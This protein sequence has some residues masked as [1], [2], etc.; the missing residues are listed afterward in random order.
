MALNEY[1]PPPGKVAISTVVEINGKRL[2]AQ[3]FA[4]AEPWSQDEQYQESMKADLLR[5][6]GEAIVKELRPEITATLSPPTL[7]E[8]LNEALRPFDY[9]Y[10]ALGL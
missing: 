1:T 7:R 4:D 10:G 3:A 5:S 2:A 6:L 8:A 9:P